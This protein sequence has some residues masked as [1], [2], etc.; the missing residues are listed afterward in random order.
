VQVIDI[1]NPVEIDIGGPKALAV[2]IVIITARF[3]HEG[4]GVD[5]LSWARLISKLE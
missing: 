5:L 4:H 3:T 2:S 1:I